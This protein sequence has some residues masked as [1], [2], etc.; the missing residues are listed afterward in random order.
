MLPIRV[1]TFDKVAQSNKVRMNKTTC[2]LINNY[3]VVIKQTSCYGKKGVWTVACRNQNTCVNP[4]KLTNLIV[5]AVLYAALGQRERI[6]YGTTVHT[7]Q[8]SDD[9][10]VRS[11]PQLQGAG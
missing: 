7:V 5:V 9:V 11:A 10:N 3:L 8:I 1:D 2:M 6:I 4:G